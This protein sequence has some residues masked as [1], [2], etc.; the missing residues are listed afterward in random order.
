MVRLAVIGLGAR[1]ADV[2]AQMRQLDASVE[3][4]AVADPDGERVWQRLERL[5]IPLEETKIYPSTDALLEYA[6]HYDGVLIGTRCHLHTPIAVRVAATRLPLFL[7]KPVAISWEQLTSLREAFRSREHTVVVSFPLRYTPLFAQVVEIARSGRLGV[8]NQVQAVNNVPYGGVYFGQWYRNYDQSGGLWLQKATH[9]FDYINHLIGTSPTMIAATSTQKVYGGDMPH[10][11]K[12]SACDLVETCLESP[13]NIRLRGDDG[14][15]YM[16]S[17][18]KSDHWCAFG[19]EICNQDAGSALILYEDG[20][21]ASYSQ[22][23]LTRRSAYRRGAV[24]TG[25]TATLEFNWA[26]ESIRVIDHHLDRVDHIKVRANTSHSGGD[27][28]LAKN[29]LDVI[30]GQ[31]KPD[32]TLHDGLLSAAMCLSARESSLRHT[33]Q[34]IQSPN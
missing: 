6:E 21:H 18:D 22:N 11:L 8:I 13:K 15:M 34:P 27:H 2:L 32:A 33:F 23:F 28:A 3:L 29:F 9:D 26:T 14:G 30:R 24:V 19:K 5:G 25:Y 17:S 16:G 4:A 31:A 12:C 7:E 1:A 20:T 10:D